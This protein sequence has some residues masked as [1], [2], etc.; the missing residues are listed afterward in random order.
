V[1]AFYADTT[2]KY[3][4]ASA[5][6]AL[7]WGAATTI[8]DANGTSFVL[9]MGVPAK[10][11]NNTF[12]LCI[13]GSA[14]SETYWNFITIANPSDY[15]LGSKIA[16]GSGIKHLQTKFVANERTNLDSYVT[17]GVFRLIVNE[18]VA[19]YSAITDVMIGMLYSKLTDDPSE[20]WLIMAD[21][22][23]DCAAIT[24]E[25]IEEWG[26]AIVPFSRY[27]ATIIGTLDA[28]TAIEGQEQELELFREDGKSKIFTC[29]STAL[30]H[31]LKIET[32]EAGDNYHVKTLEFTGIP[33]GR[34][35]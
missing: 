27:T 9:E 34:A 17:I 12:N 32:K 25:E 6:S 10:P 21:E 16:L 22:E 15:S 2:I 1:Y 19:E 28:Y 3:S 35:F 20:N 13:A 29:Y 11:V 31:L 26:E 4:K 14:G 33:A 8:L 7:I 23:V 18:A 30:F 24:P 5:L